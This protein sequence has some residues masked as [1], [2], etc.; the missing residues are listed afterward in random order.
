MEP[1]TCP[2]EMS[3]DLP[4]GRPIHDAPAGCD[5]KPVCLMH[6]LDPNKPH[7]EFKREV[8][9]ILA[10]SSSQHRPKFCFDFSGFVFLVADFRGR[11]FDKK[12][13][14]SGATF[15]RTANFTNVTFTEVADFHLAT[16]AKK[17][18]YRNAIFANN[19]E[20]SWTTFTEEVIF[21]GARFN[22]TADFIGATFTKDVNFASGTF[23]MA[24]DF[25]E[26][27]FTKGAYF[28][29][30]TFTAEISFDH[31][32]F[33]DE[34][35]FTQATFD[36][37][38]NFGRVTFT[39]AGNFQKANFTL[40]AIFFGATFCDM[41]FFDDTVFDSRSNALSSGAVPSTI[42]DFR[43]VRFLKPDLV[44]FLRTNGKETEG[45]RVRFVNSHVEGVQFDAVRWHRTDGR[46][47]LQ[48]EL[49]V[50]EQGE[51]APSHEE[52]AI[53]YRRLITNFEKAR[54]YDLVEDCTI[55]EFEMKRRDPSRFIFAG[56][57]DT[58]YER[59]SL[60]RRWI[61]EQVSV[62]GIYRLASVYGTSYHR[63]L[64]VLGFLLIGFGVLFSTVVD[65][66][67]MNVNA[68][69]I[70][71]Q[72]SAGGALCAGLTHAVEV[73]ALQKDLL[74]VPVS[75][76]GRMTEVLEQVLIAGQVALL[77]F[78][79]RRRFRR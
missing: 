19:A 10:S 25:A 30:A 73:A 39:G 52:T 26:A 57:L 65:I 46:M 22:R 17:S 59:F 77:L 71:D 36:K 1:N 53:V 2:I 45:L 72:S 27:T 44:R 37:G 5:E 29:G 9:A 13:D 58:F 62:V 34:A 51:D 31:A 24:T 38:A 35:N 32:T 78:A 14:F 12:T 4:C 66:K 70:C 43:A 60:L 11:T 50:I 8:D 63:A 54:A 79:L 61:G 40:E 75:S 23:G 68:I 64:A 47:V 7:D 16:F 18:Y 76:S 42:A 56:V 48:D 74:Y 3:D 6:S 20:F 33:T 21:G 69:S 41:A 15:T 49:D 28:Y 67:P 55:G